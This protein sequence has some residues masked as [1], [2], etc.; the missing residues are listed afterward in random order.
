MTHA[1]EATTVD[2][3]EDPPL[4]PHQLQAHRPLADEQAGDDGWVFCDVLLIH[5]IG[6]LVVHC[7]FIGVVAVSETPSRTF[8]V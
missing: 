7:I 8:A 1:Q 3:P 2:D 6:I 5:P 4:G